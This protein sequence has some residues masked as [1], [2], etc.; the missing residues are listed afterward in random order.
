MLVLLAQFV[1]KLV[2]LME[3]TDTALCVNEFNQSQ[4]THTQKD[5]QNI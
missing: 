3:P 5:T 4:P 1:T 2:N